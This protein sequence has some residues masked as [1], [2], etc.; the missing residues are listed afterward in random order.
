MSLTESATISLNAP[1]H[2]FVGGTW[3]K[4]SSSSVI[5][6]INAS[7]E[8]V[9]FQVAEAKAEDM[10]KAVGAAREA[11]D[12]G[13]WPHLSHA[14]RADYLRKIATALEAR[15][16]EISEIWSGQMGVLHS[17]A[18]AGGAGFGN[19]FRYYAGLAD[20]FPFVERHA[21]TSGGNVGLLVKEPVGVVGAIIPWNGPVGLIA[22]KV[23]PALL[24]GCTVILKA[25][26]EAPGEAYIFAEIA[27]AIGIPP[28][29]I[30]VVTADREVSELLVTDPRVDKITFT[31]STAAG[32]RIASLC[33]ER[34]ARVTLEL[35]GKSAA[36]VLDDYDIAT[37][38]KAITGRACMMTGQVCSSL[39]R[40]V[41]GRDRHDELVE[42]LSES[43]SG[44]QVGSAFDP[45][46]GMGPLAMERQR[47]RVEGYIAKGI[48]EGATL[49]TGGGR[50]AGLDRGW[51]IEPT[52]FGNVDN[53]YT[54]AQEEI[55]GPVL[56]VIPADDEQH[57][58]DIANDTIYGLNNSV[59][60]NDAD[61]AYEVA[62]QLRSGT[63][64][65]NSFRTDFGIA[66]GGFKQSGIGREG[67]REGLLP[68]LEPKT[69]ILDDEPS[70]IHS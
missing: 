54:I 11:F 5:D 52:V 46:S 13:P 58:I 43:F 68:F 16:P 2:F 57:A 66:F 48:D 64:G 63:V 36:V 18:K 23:A 17:M 10:A 51:F 55:F 50:P 49:A 47:D 44:I 59:F 35:G 15:S 1:D 53:A 7:T 29:V 65:Q 61:R 31:G 21:P 30:N 22:H 39:T 38:A 37:A 9:M 42:A 45:K 60:T 12:H 34:I 25:S 14:E 33:G 62:R 24:A 20:D 32:R 26:P 6:V 41:V 69:I 19:P 3:V 4:P 56:S 67:G 8:D 70:R 28:G 40:I 27:E